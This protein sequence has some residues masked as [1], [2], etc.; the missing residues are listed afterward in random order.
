MASATG[1]A[2]STCRRCPTPSMTHSSMSGTAERRSSA[3]STHRRPVSPPTTDSVGRRIAAASSGPNRQSALLACEE[4]RPYVRRELGWP[5]TEL[6]RIRLRRGDLTG[7]EE[8]L[9]DAHRLGWDPE[10]V[11][12]LVRLADGDA[13]TA[14]ATID[15]ALMRPRPVPSKELPPPPSCAG[16]RCWTRR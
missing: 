1:R 5:L 13:D 9:R 3:T 11:L 16:R 8:A 7:A 4:L 2:R 10:P 12:S 6:G 15:E 14:A